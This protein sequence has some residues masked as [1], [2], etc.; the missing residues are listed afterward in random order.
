MQ[1]QFI[2]DLRIKIKSQK[3]EWSRVFWV[4]ETGNNYKIIFS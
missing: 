1:L 3:A 4:G 2:N